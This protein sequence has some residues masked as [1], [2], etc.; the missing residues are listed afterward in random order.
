MN[1]QEIAGTVHQYQD[2]HAWK[3]LMAI[4]A[5]GVGS[6]A[7]AKHLGCT[8]QTMSSWKACRHP[9]SEEWVPKIYALI[10]ECV[11]SKEQTIAILKSKGAWNAPMRRVTNAKFAKLK[12]VYDARPQQYRDVA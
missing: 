3:A 5:F 6:A 10:A 12:K 9:I 2:H 7:L 4:L 8:P 1:A 11:A